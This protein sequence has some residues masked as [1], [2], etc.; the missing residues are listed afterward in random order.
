MLQEG[1]LVAFPT[2]TVYGLAVRA[3]DKQ[4]VAR[5]YRTKG[6]PSY[7]PLIVHMCSL[8]Q[9]E[10]LAYFTPLAYRLAEAFW[11]GPMTLVLQRR[12]DACLAENVYAGLSTVA[13]RLPSHQ[14][15]RRL[16]SLCDFALAAPSANRSSYLST[17]VADD[18]LADLGSDIAGVIDGGQSALGLESTIID[19]RG[20]QARVLRWG[21]LPASSLRA[22]VAWRDGHHKNR[23]RPIAPGM[24][25]RHYAPRTPMRLQ[26]R[27]FYDDEA[28][29]LFGADCPSGG[30][31]RLN[32]SR[33]GNLAEA[34]A[35]FYRMLH[36]LD[37]A[38]CARIAVMPIVDKGLGIV[39]N[40]RLQRAVAGVS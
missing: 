38:G 35:G 10:A 14:C 39:L 20:R 33:Q 6:R 12:A 29:L 9:G 22:V 40:E 30:C 34:A 19:A 2:E 13:L 26:A 28:V 36:Q 17:T 25:A 24:L 23:V 27:S 8:A 16:L 15:A 31:I 11:P 1:H 3:D 4:A 32:L 5:L 18:V 21:S 37:R 7:N